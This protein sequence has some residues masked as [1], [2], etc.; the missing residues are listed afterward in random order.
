LMP[1]RVP[2]GGA[3]RLVDL[4]DVADV[5][6]IAEGI[7]TALAASVLHRLPVWAALNAG[8]LE[9]WCPPETIRSVFVFGDND[10]GFAGQK[11]TYAL[12]HRLST[13]WRVEVRI[14]PEPGT[15]W[16]DVLRHRMG[17]AA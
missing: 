17:V 10:D 4:A 13:K 7:E 6:G 11:A 5:L 14:P 15:D 9:A 1:G 3:V 8:A 12:A 2:K 16:N